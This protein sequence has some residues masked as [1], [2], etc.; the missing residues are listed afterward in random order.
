MPAMP[1]LPGIL[2]IILTRFM[3]RN[4]AIPIIPGMTG[5]PVM[6]DMLGMPGKPGIPEMFLISGMTEIPAIPVRIVRVCL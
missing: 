6:P 1:E 5:I 2:R 4:M 3:S